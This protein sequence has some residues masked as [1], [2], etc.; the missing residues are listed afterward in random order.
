MNMDTPLEK[1]SKIIV[2]GFGTWAMAAVNPSARIVEHLQRHARADSQIVAIEMPVNSTELC[3]RVERILLDERPD[4]WIGIGLAPGSPTIRAE[5]VGIN[6]LH[7]EVPDAAGDS[8]QQQPVME[9]GPAAFNATLPNAEI[10]GAIRAG[11]IPACLSFWA[12]THL[13]NQMLYVVNYLVEKHGLN[14]LCGFLHVPYAADQVVEPDE[15]GRLYAS[16]GIGTMCD[17]VE[18]AIACVE[19][20]LSESVRDG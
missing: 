15:G 19:A 4:A 3:D 11:G 16:M 12:G 17:A 6:W 1:R 10:V 20:T 13:C 2:A 14:T 18:R 7:T 8:F 9:G 5:M